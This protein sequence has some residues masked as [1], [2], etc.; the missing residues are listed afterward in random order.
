MRNN[1]KMDPNVTRSLRAP[2]IDTLVELLQTAFPENER[3]KTGVLPLLSNKKAYVKY[4]LDM[5][6]NRV[7]PLLS[8]MEVQQSCNEFYRNHAD[9][10][11]TFQLSYGDVSINTE[12]KYIHMFNVTESGVPGSFGL[13]PYSG[14]YQQVQF[15]GDLSFDKL[16]G[17][18]I[19]FDRESK[20]INL[21]ESL[22]KIL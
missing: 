11:A 8:A 2:E 1:I 16:F 10:E 20:S 13:D 17:Y 14:K 22:K 5:W 9:L 21:Y 12:K 15:E 18:L 4:L 7:V 3:I 19:D 6:D